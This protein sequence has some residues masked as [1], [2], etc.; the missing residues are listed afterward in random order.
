MEKQ[1][2]RVFT[3][4]SDAPFLDILAREIFRGFPTGSP[5]RDLAGLTI[6]VPTRRSARELQFKLLE[7]SAQRALVLP[8]I[9][10]IGDIDEDV[11]E[12]GATD[13]Q[14]PNAISPIGRQFALMGFIGEWLTQNPQLR[15][16]EEIAN[17]PQ[18]TLALA[19]SLGELIDTLETDEVSL[20]RLQE[21]YLIDLANHR[22]A[23]L[24][25]LD[26]VRKKLP[27]MLHAEN[28]M[29]G[30]ER[31]SRLIRL[32]A[33]RLRESP[34]KGPIIA[35]GSTGT[36][37]A[38]RELLKAISQLENGAV[39]LPG[40]DQELD[41]E[42]W[43]HVSPQHPQ[44]ALKQLLEDFGIGRTEV[45]V[46]GPAAGNRS[47]VA[48]EL[49]RP[50]ATADKWLTTLSSQQQRMREALKHLA[51]IKGRDKNEEAA[52]IALVMRRE[53]EKAQGDIALVTPDRDLARR[54]KAALLRW[55]IRVDDSAGEPLIRFGA[56]AL[57]AF[58][59]DVVSNDFSAPSLGV[60]FAHPLSKFGMERHAFQRIAGNIDLVLFRDNPIGPGLKGFAHAF[61]RV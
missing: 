32:Q 36:I 3:I 23:I 61:E 49:M 58:L 51:L 42:S 55:N 24:G 40:L 21:A 7:M 60:L 53:L 39:V 6:L 41:D 15:L 25:L 9:R 2:S 4:A 34:P 8:A 59:I 13:A 17:S 52:I 27:A 48:T 28:L 31:R 11:L 38:T 5:A 43:N 44:F 37:P 26:L 47:W 33:Q 50:S 22:E 10:P 29:G 56:A 45:S 14:L 16:A 1:R 54:V 57:L 30:R 12:I 18:Q 20:D 46:L 19:L 35:A